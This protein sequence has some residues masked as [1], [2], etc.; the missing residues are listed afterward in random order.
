MDSEK[1]PILHVF[2]LATLL[3]PKINERRNFPSI[4][5]SDVRVD[6][7]YNRILYSSRFSFSLSPLKMAHKRRATSLATVN[8]RRYPVISSLS[9]EAERA[10]LRRAGALPTISISLTSPSCRLQ[11]STLVG[12]IYLPVINVMV[13]V[14]CAV[15]SWAELSWIEPNRA[16]PFRKRSANR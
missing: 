16:E 1:N 9:R 12:I 2:S 6:S 3:R 15:P 10:T 7:F 13:D 11:N 4:Q 5:A 14:E 8:S